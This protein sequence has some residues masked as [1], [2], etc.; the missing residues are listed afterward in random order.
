MIP[1]LKIIDDILQGLPENARLRAQLGEL[2]AQVE[3]LQQELDTARSEL[4]RLNQQQKAPDRLQD[5]SEKML[6][7]IANDTT[8]KV[9][10]KIV[11]HHLGLSQ[12]K[13]DY[14]FDQL[15]TDKLVDTSSG[16][17]GIGWFYHAT[18]AGREYLAKHGLL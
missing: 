5:E 13:G 18:K 1:G 16:Q 11:I 4:R 3:K 8:G 2:R 14:F 6:V 17:M 7:L 15:L 10:S 12:A 9:T